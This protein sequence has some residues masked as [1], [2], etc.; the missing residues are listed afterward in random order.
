MLI[1]SSDW[2]PPTKDV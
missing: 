1:V 2:R